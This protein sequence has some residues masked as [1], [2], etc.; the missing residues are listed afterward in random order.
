MRNCILLHIVFVCV[1]ARDKFCF[2]LFCI[3]GQIRLL[4][5][6]YWR[7]LTSVT[8][9]VISPVCSRSFSRP[10]HAFFVLLAGRQSSLSVR[11]FRSCAPL[12]PLGHFGWIHIR[13]SSKWIIRNSFYR[14]FVCRNSFSQWTIHIQLYNQSSLCV[15]RFRSFTTPLTPLRHFGWIHMC[16]SSQ[17]IINNRFYKTIRVSQ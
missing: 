14:I 9:L 3:K 17:W 2:H 6:I 15:R 8:R 10:S 12:T 4:H 16:S 7:H 11:R 5:I 13:S 1:Q